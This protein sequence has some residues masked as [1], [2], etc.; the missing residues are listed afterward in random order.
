M[1]ICNMR[2]SADR[3]CNF[4]C[5]T[6][7]LSLG[8]SPNPPIPAFQTLRYNRS[9]LG[10]VL[11]SMYMQVRKLRECPSMIYKHYFPP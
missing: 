5:R 11:G 1:Y 4:K 9:S 7:A 6:Q 3:F 8:H 2:W 10:N